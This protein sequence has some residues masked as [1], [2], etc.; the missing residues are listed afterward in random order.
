MRRKPSPSGE[1]RRRAE[2]AIGPR[3]SAQSY[4]EYEIALLQKEIQFR[5]EELAVSQDE[6][7]RARAKFRHLYE[8]TPLG[9]AT[10]DANFE[11][12]EVNQKLCQALGVDRAGLCGA[13]FA[14]LLDAEDGA[15]LRRVV[16]A[17]AEGA[18]AELEVDLVRADGTPWP[19]LLEMVRADDDG[20]RVAVTRRT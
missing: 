14:T 10:L 1:L 19:V 20:W 4:V 16:Q 11:I 18:L 7:E 6:L 8:H 2:Q 9:F 5:R 13:P 12:I 17:T 15:E 3:A